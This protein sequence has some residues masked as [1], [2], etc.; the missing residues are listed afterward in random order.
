M[1][2]NFWSDVC[3]YSILC[4]PY[5]EPHLSLMI[6]CQT[7]N[8]LSS[9]MSILMHSAYCHD[10]ID[11]KLFLE[12]RYQGQQSEIKLIYSY[13]MLRKYK[14][15]SSKYHLMISKIHIINLLLIYLDRFISFVIY[16]TSSH[17]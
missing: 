4:V 17:F 16:A 3:V 14:Y 8:I 9:L 7:N 10:T 5:T 15:K 11:F 2:V 1:Q 6:Y 12:F 13:F